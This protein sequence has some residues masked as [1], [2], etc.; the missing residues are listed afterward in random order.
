MRIAIFGAGGIGSLFGAMLARSGEEVHFIAR[1]AGLGAIR[2]SGIRV[3]S[4]QGDFTVPPQPA[5]DD[6]ARIGPVDAVLLCVK[7]WQV[8]EAAAAMAPL[9]GSETA[10]L[11]LQNGVEAPDQLSAAVPKRHVL[12]G[13]TRVVCFLDSPG[14]V[15]HVGVSPYIALGE[16]DD[17]RTSRVELL[18][19]A[20]A[21]SGIEVEIPETIAA[22]MWE[23]FIFIS[24]ISGLG[25]AARAPFGVLRHLPGTRR[26]F[27]DAILEGVRLAERLEIPIAADYPEATLAFFERMPE[28]GTASMQRDIMDGHPSE[29]ETQNGAMVR[30]G[31]K[32]GIPTPTH[33]F[34]Y[35]VLLPQERQARGNGDI[36]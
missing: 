21:R 9:L 6:P 13:M 11:P 18:A 35:H 12:G 2:E 27:E 25:A 34:L 19:A 16:L 29:L 8:P 32:L 17:A 14:V 28:D 24:A 1:G 5:S 7:S 36:G 33:A 4:P 30:F 10:V 20:L 22:S 15:R 31:E 26:M 3:F 23:K